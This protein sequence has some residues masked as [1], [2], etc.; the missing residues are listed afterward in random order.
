EAKVADFWKQLPP[1]QSHFEGVPEGEV[2][3]RGRREQSYQVF[4]R[5]KI[6][7]QWFAALLSMR[8][9]EAFSVQARFQSWRGLMDFLLDREAL[10]EVWA[11]SDGAE[12]ARR[13]TATELGELKKQ[14]REQPTFLTITYRQN[15]TGEVIT[16]RLEFN[17]KAVSEMLASIAGYQRQ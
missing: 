11:Y 4:L 5:E 6:K 17:F 14:S 15:T 13:I 12:K 16:N 10:V 1:P 2:K 3:N 7:G 9:E 8:S